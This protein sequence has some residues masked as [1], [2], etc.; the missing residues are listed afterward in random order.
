M[1]A[2]SCGEFRPFKRIPISAEL[3]MCAYV[4][5]R[6]FTMWRSVCSLSH[7]HCPQAAINYRRVSSARTPPPLSLSTTL[8]VSLSSQ[9]TPMTMVTIATTKTTTKAVAISESWRYFSPCLPSGLYQ[10]YLQRRL[11]LNAQNC[12]GDKKNQTITKSEKKVKSTFVINE[13]L[14]YFVPFVKEETMRKDLQ[15][16]TEVSQECSLSLSLKDPVKRT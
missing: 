8:A 13:P 12:S 9:A 15:I 4:C 14:L 7:F 2:Y 5:S 1:V 3:G 16:W 6:V 10:G 11:L